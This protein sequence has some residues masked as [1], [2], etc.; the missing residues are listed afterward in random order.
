MESNTLGFNLADNSSEFTSS[1]FLQRTNPELIHKTVESSIPLRWAGCVEQTSLADISGAESLRH[2]TILEE[3]STSSL[4]F[5]RLDQVLLEVNQ[6]HGVCIHQNGVLERAEEIGN[7][8]VPEPIEVAAVFRGQRTMSID[9]PQFL[10]RE[11]LLDLLF[12]LRH[13]LD[14]LLLKDIIQVIN[15]TFQFQILGGSGNMDQSL[16]MILVQITVMEDLDR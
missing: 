13:L 3:I 10:W 7:Q 2:F 8:L 11:Q 15:D 5:P 12:G 16:L 6:W 14:S 1:Y 4:E 9:K